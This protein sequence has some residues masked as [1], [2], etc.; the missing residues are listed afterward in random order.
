M[1]GGGSDVLQLYWGDCITWNTV[2][3]RSTGLDF[4]KHQDGIFTGNYV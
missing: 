2:A 3:D 4:A 1:Y